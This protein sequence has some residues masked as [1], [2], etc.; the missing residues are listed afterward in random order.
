MSHK[1]GPEIDKTEKLMKESHRKYMKLN[2]KETLLCA[3]DRAKLY[4]KNL[5]LHRF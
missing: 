4:R 3:P 1:E 2:Y 5:K